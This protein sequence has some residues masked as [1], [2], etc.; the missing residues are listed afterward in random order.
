MIIINGEMR[1][2]LI[3]PSSSYDNSLVR[4]DGTTGAIQNGT[5]Y[6]S[7]TGR[8]GIGTASPG[9]SIDIVSTDSGKIN[10][11]SANHSQIILDRGASART[12]S[13]TIATAGTAT[14]K[15]GLF[16]NETFFKI[17]NIGET[18]NWLTCGSAGN[19]GIGE[20]TP[21]SY[22][23]GA[24]CLLQLSGSGQ[25]SSVAITR[26]SANELPSRLFMAKSRNS[27]IGT[28]AI[29]NDDDIIGDISFIASDGVNFGTMPAQIYAEVDDSSPTA[30][31]IG[32]ALVFLT[33][34][35][36]SAD[37]I[38]EAGRFN[39]LGNLGVGAVVTPAGKVHIDQSS[40]TGALPVLVIDQAD[41]SEEFIKFIGSSTI[42]A[43]QS[44]VDAADMTTPGAIVGW[45]KIYVQDDQATDPITDGY[46]FVPFYSSPTS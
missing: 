25:E 28:H 17:T 42:D 13:I 16:A 45:I 37:D 34:A 2:A 22:N 46:Y 12:A 32:G 6:A 39:R 21:E 19:I 43:S 10:I 41:V 3:R 35:G 30:N 40:S 14:H 27:T 23:A 20:S 1:T 24:T 4:F 29:L 36:N 38:T 9:Y 11:D 26:W 5:I 8:L 15:F 33:A 18:A 7:D 44:L 31:G